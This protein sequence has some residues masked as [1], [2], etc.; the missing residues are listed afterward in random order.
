MGVDDRAKVVEGKVQDVRGNVCGDVQDVRADVRYIRGDVQDVDNNVQYVD[1]WI[2]G[3]NNNVRG[4]DGKLA[5]VNVRYPFSPSSSFQM[6][7]WLRPLH[8]VP[9]QTESFFLR[10][11]SPPDPSTNR[12]PACKWVITDSSAQWFFQNFKAPAWIARRCQQNDMIPSISNVS[13]TP[14]PGAHTG[15]L[16]TIL[17]Y[18]IVN[19]SPRSIPDGQS[20]V[21]TGWTV[22]FFKIQMSKAWA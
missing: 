18:A 15:P 5:H 10:W 6:A 4:V 14:T 21:H 22:V 1:D 19:G 12:N 3:I 13:N 9:A 16:I 8:R 20:T 2:Q 7:H 11:L 17:G